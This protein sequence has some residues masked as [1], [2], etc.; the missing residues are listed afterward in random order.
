MTHS[1]WSIS[2]S[3]LVILAAVVLRYG[4]EKQ[5]DRESLKP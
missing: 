5:Q 2:M 1:S 4:V 3:S